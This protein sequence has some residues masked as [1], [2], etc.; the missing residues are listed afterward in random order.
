MS[1]KSIAKYKRNTLVSYQSKAKENKSKNNVNKVFDVIQVML[2]NS[3]LYTQTCVRT[4][5]YREE[6][7]TKR[8]ATEIRINV[9]VETR[10]HTLKNYLFSS[11]SLLPMLCSSNRTDQTDKISSRSLQTAATK[12][13][14]SVSNIDR[15]RFTLKLNLFTIMDHRN[16]YQFADVSSV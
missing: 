3:Q 13:D 2:L 14:K 1:N 5:F 9:A 11:K 4:Q 8:T 12:K 10:H 15:H 6:F 7:Q 16:P